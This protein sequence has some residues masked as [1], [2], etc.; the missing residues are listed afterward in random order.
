MLVLWPSV[1]SYLLVNLSEA[2]QGETCIVLTDFA[3]SDWGGKGTYIP[4]TALTIS[5]LILSCKSGFF[6]IQNCLGICPSTY[7]RTS[8]SVARIS[9]E[10]LPSNSFSIS[11]MKR[12][13]AKR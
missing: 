3:Y 8:S 9:N 7:L 1:L 10:I 11:G 5:V 12:E 4:P 13:V 2:V 6:W